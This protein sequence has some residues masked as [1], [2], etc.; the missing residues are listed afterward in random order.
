VTE[1]IPVLANPVTGYNIVLRDNIGVNFQMNLADTDEVIATVNG[2]VVSLEKNGNIISV[3]VA[4]AQMM[5]EIAICV[6][7]MPLA[8]TY[9]VRGYADYILNGDYSDATKELVKY[10]LV[11]GGAAQTYFG[12]NS[13][14]AENLASNGITVVAKVPTGDGKVE[15]SGKVTGASFYGATLVHETKTTVRFYFTG[16]LDGLTVTAN[17]GEAV[18]G[19]KN[20]MTYVEVS[21][22]NPQDLGTDV[23]VTVSDGTNTLSISYSPLDYLVRMYNKADSSAAHKALIQ[24]LYGYYVSAAAYTA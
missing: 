14:S 4:A 1:E 2:A 9:T 22:I 16:N 6:N 13:D 8:N 21:G 3:S 10:M 23:V 5:D 19:A 11:Y 15:M 7:G 24:A 17:G 12:Y 18:I 20:N